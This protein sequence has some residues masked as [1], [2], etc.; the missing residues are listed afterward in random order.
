MDIQIALNWT[1]QVLVMGFVIVM[2]M[3]FVNGLFWLPYSAIAP[4]AT[5]NYALATIPSTS[6][7]PVPALIP[8][9]ATPAPQFAQLPNP[10]ELTEISAI[11]IQPQPVVLE[12]PSLPL[13]LP[14][15]QV[16]P[17]TTKPKSTKAK[18]SKPKSTKTTPTS[19]RKT[20]VTPCKQSK[21]SAA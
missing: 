15:A 18:A 9:I 11:P 13:L 2:V 5:P 4:T 7:E 16:Q 19:K 20:P 12:F 8:P 10:W 1:I 21:K 3:D 14:A 17:T 6:P